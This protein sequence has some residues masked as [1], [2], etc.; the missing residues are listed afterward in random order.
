MYL[1]NSDK[2][3]YKTPTA[4]KILWIKLKQSTEKMT[5]VFTKPS[6]QDPENEND[7][8]VYEEWITAVNIF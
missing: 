5:V 3:V 8:P 2:S 6:E 1:S 4:A 7:L